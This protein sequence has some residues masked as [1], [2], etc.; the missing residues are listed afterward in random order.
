MVALLGQRL[1]FTTPCDLQP[2]IH[3]SA[4]LKLVT[5]DSNLPRKQIVGCG[6][7]KRV[8][9]SP[10]APRL[11]LDR[12]PLGKLITAEPTSFTYIGSPMVFSRLN[13]LGRS[14]NRSCGHCVMPGRFPAPSITPPNFRELGPC[15]GTYR[16]IATQMIPDLIST[17]GH[18]IGKNLSGQDPCTCC[19]RALG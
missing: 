4:L 6:D 5:F 14:R 9:R 15:R 8:R 2:S 12:S 19:P 11:V 13:Q 1:Q 7:Y 18:G 17:A 10:G 3:G 16:V